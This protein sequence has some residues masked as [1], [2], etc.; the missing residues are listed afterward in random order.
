M[1]KTIPDGTALTEI[2]EEEMPQGMER[3]LVLRLLSHWRTLCDDRDY[4]S[5][6]DLD[7]SAIPDM[8]KNCFV[9]EIFEDGSEPRYRAMGEALTAQ[10][11]FSLK[12]QLISMSP[13][14]SLPAVAVSFLKEVLAKGVPISRGDEYLKDDGTKVLYRSILLP[15]SDDGDTVNGILGAVNCREVI[16]G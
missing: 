7:P 14:K 15:M 2:T 10:V 13:E 8:W 11:D 4:P 3:R 1:D 9:L 6:F 5:F 16:E 12:D